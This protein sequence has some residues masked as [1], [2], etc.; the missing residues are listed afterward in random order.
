MAFAVLSRQNPKSGLDIQLKGRVFLD[1]G[2]KSGGGDATPATKC[3][4]RVKS[5]RKTLRK[6]SRCWC[7]LGWN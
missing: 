6:A 3:A 2:G 4:M 7:G 1:V 5:G